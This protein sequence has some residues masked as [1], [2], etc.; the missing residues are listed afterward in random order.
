MYHGGMI[1]GKLYDAFNVTK[2]VNYGKNIIKGF[3]RPLNEGSFHKLI[4]E[5]RTIKKFH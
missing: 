3:S 4:K 5:K 2:Y 1:I